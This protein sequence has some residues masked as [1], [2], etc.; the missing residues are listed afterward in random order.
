MPRPNKGLCF[1]DI[2]SEKV[3]AQRFDSKLPVVTHSS[4]E[5]SVKSDLVV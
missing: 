3:P 5:N 1:A 2:E 4:F